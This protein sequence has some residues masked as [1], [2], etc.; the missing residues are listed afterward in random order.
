MRCPKCNFKKTIVVD[1]R[2]SNNTIK[3]RRECTACGYRFNTYESVI[4][5]SDNIPE[6]L[7]KA[8]KQYLNNN[9]NNISINDFDELEKCLISLTQDE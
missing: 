7:R 4:H 2:S 6:H 8:I 3:R 5:V 9:N 1:S